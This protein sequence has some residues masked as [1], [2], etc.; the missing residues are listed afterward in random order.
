MVHDPYAGDGFVFPKTNC[1]R[2]RRFFIKRLNEIH[3][4]LYITKHAFD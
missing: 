2:E 4:L 1:T 3:A